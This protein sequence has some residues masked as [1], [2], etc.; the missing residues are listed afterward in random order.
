MDKRCRHTTLNLPTS[1]IKLVFLVR[2]LDYGGAQRR[3]LTLAQGL[4]KR[5]F[6][7]T[8]LSFYSNQPLEAEIDGSSVRLISLRK[9][10][11]WDVLP[12]YLRLYQQVWRLQPDVLHSW[13]DVPNVLAVC[14][15]PFV[16]ARVVWG[17][18]TSNIDLRRYDYLFR[19]AAKCERLLARFADLIIINSTAG[20]E[21]HV[22]RGFPRAKMVVIPN[23]IDVEHF[24]PDLKAREEFRS[25]LA[26]PNDTKLVGIVGRFDPM[27]D[28]PTFLQ[29]AALLS[30][31][32]NNIRFI[33]VGTGSESYLG[34]LEALARDLGMAEQIFW[35]EARRDVATVYN[36]LDVLVS[37]SASEGVSNAVAEAMACG[38]PCVV[39]DVGDSALL[40]GDCGIVVAPTGPQALAD[41]ITRCLAADREEWGAKA[42]EQIVENFSVARMVKLTETAIDSATPPG[43]ARL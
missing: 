22:A 7:I 12:F 11:R 28:H 36:G 17:L 26:L 6:D 37:S 5:R 15:K 31:E 33:C 39:T 2:S 19:L 43:N 10:G 23:G 21:H 41:G 16:N 38:V 29:A 30:Q 27:K 20:F 4:D 9:R 18:G 40:V 24:R 32:V 42:R 1:S 25:Q 8:I 3:L 13:L 34:E 14:L 35:M